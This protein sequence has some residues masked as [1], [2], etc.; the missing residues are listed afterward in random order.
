MTTRRESHIQKLASNFT[1]YL[2][3]EARCTYAQ[4]TND[5]EPNA[6]KPPAFGP[7]TRELVV[8]T[9]PQGTVNK[10]L[11]QTQPLSRGSLKSRQSAK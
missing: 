5:R 10:L 9:L 3:V 6:L 7:P 4:V 1:Y 11:N 2:S 8:R